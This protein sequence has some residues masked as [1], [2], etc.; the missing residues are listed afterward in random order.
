MLGAVGRWQRYW[1]A[2]GGRTALAIVRICVAASV[3]LSLIKLA[4]AQ[5]PVAA[6]VYRPVG[7]WMLAGAQAPP[8]ELVSLLWVV[9]WASTAAMALG[10]AS[11]ASTA[12]SFLS[13][14][15][16]V[17]LSFSASRTWS[18]QYNVVFLAQLALLGARSGDTL[19]LDWLIQTRVR[20]LPP[21]DEP[22]AYQWS[23]RLVQLAVVL[24]FAGAAFHKLLHGHFTL[25]WALSDN[26][27]HHLLVRYDLAGNARPPV[28]DWLLA[29]A[30]RYQGAALLNMITQ[31]APLVAV[32][33][34]KRPLVRAFAGVLFV[35]EVIMLG[36][37]VGLWNLHWLPLVAV[38]LDWERLIARVRGRPLPAHPAAPA[39]WRP[40]RPVTVFVVAFVVYDVLTGFVPTLDQR[41]NTYPFSGFPMFATIRARAPYGEHQPYSIVGGSYEVFTDLTL[42]HRTQRW[43]D[44]A[45][46]TVHVVRDPDELERRLRDVLARAQHFYPDW[47]IRGIRLWITVYE[48]PAHPAPARFDRHRIAI[49]GELAAD[50]SFRTLLGK[51]DRDPEHGYIELRPRGIDVPADTELVYYRDDRA[52]PHSIPVAL[53]GLRF[54]LGY[55]PLPGNPRYF[56]ALVGGTP[57][58]VASDARWRW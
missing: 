58:L 39:S 1:F 21:R 15:A 12:I 2:D 46:R 52:E 57:W 30:W 51:L 41:L 45:H 55:Q 54:D 23:L 44:H 36:V 35:I 13:A 47:H 33:F 17:S 25:R 27:R 5:S 20:K 53:D 26:L 11:R 50:G 7:V 28:V 37:V 4:G 22:R 10:L 14:V 31:A 34:I 18:H 32:F 29:E 56:V 38:F 49:L 3:L 9:A 6:S 48:A 16:L 19:S 40:P 42:D 43:I 24:M 8:A